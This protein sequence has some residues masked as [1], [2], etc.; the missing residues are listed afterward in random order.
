MQGGAA[1][2]S[3]LGGP[4]AMFQGPL[5]QR[6]EGEGSEEKDAER[7]VGFACSWS[8]QEISLAP[9]Q[10]HKAGCAVREVSGCWAQ[11]REAIRGSGASFWGI[12]D[13]PGGF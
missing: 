13:A 4:E 8:S 6:R 3:A 12:R 7:G 9:G 10:E 5:Q 2:C 11:T 1:C